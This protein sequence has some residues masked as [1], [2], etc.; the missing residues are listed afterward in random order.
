VVSFEGL[1]SRNGISYDG[2]FNT[3]GADTIITN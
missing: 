1:V 2:T 3:V